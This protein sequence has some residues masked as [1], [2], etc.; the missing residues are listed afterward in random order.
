MAC[1]PVEVFLYLEVKELHA[2]YIYIYIFSVVVAEFFF[3][4]V[5]LSYSILRFQII[6]SI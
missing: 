2:L 3:Y 4:T 5:F 6:I 1:Q